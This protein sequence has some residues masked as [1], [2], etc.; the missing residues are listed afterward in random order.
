MPI[1]NRCVAYHWRSMPLVPDVNRKHFYIKI[2]GKIVNAFIFENKYLENTAQSAKI[3][4]FLHLMQVS[5]NS[6]A[7]TGFFSGEKRTWYFYPPPTPLL[8]TNVSEAYAKKPPQSTPIHLIFNSYHMWKIIHKKA[9][10]L[11]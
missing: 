2:N 6:G 7:S 8:H 11:D 5:M 9:S 4:I 10:F 1:G 3:I